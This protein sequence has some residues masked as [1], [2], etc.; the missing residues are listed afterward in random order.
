MTPSFSTARKIS[1]FDDYET[2]EREWS[3]RNISYIDDFETD[4]N[5]SHKEKF[6]FYG[7]Y[8]GW[9]PRSQLFSRKLLLGEKIKNDSVDQAE[10][11]DI[12]ILVGFHGSSILEFRS[13]FCK[14][15]GCS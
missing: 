10:S 13:E 4:K 3:A 1:Y 8:L 7:P 14:C 11:V 5:L 6:L 15:V 2:F 12:K 9:I